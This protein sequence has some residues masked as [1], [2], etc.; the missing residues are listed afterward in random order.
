[1]CREQATPK[2]YERR[3]KCSGKLRLA[4]L[5]D[6]SMLELKSPRSFS[7]APCAAASMFFVKVPACESLSPDEGWDVEVWLEEVVVGLEESVKGNG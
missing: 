6:L 3:G 5:N 2:I 4:S 7:P 1:M